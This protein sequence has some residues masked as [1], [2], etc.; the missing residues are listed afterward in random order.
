[1]T[2]VQDDFTS[3]FTAPVNNSIDER[4]FTILPFIDDRFPAHEKGPADTISKTALGP[5]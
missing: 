2:N 3:L 4:Y 1:M 5:I